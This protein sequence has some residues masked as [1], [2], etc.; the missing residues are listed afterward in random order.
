M[1]D[2]PLLVIYDAHC[3]LC[4]AARRWL[5]R[6]ASARA[7]EF[8]GCQSEERARRAPAV[9]EEACLEAM[10]VVWPDGA[11]RAGAEALPGLLERVPRWRWLGSALRLPGLRQLAGPA[12][13]FIARHRFRTC[14]TNH[15]AR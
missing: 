2:T 1:S 14:G 4:R 11:L 13:R 5:E 6:R 10:Y 3:P 7:L 15:C 8:I 12:Y 9:P